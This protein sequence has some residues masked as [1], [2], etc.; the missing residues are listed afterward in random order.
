MTPD[1]KEALVFAHRENIERYRRLLN[2]QLTATEREFIERRL[3]EEEAAL[4]EFAERA[5][6]MGCPNAA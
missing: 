2:T 3:G 4:L 1:M 5:A 6:R